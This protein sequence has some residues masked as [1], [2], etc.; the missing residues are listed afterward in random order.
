MAWVDIPNTD[1]DVGSYGREDLVFQRF[2][3]NLRALRQA[4]FPWLFAEVSTTSTTYVTLAGTTKVVWIPDLPDYS[5][6]ARKV[7]L[8]FEGK[9]TATQATF[10]LRDVGSGN[11]SAT[12]VS[13]ASANYVDLTLDLAVDS[14]WKGTLRT[15]ELQALV[16]SGGQGYARVIDRVASTLDY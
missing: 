9:C 8:R 15:F 10:R 4:L 14:S 5:G 7:T 12:P 6:L 16:T 11:V 3:D 1:I 13:T 2:R